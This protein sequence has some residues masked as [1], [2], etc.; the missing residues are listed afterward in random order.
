MNGLAP[1]ASADRTHNALRPTRFDEIVGQEK[2]KKLM[3]RAIRSCYDRAHPLPHTLLVGASGTGKS[4]FSHVIANELGGIDIYSCEAPVSTDL[5]AELRTTMHGGDILMIEEIHQQA[6]MERRG[7]SGAT[8]PE[9]LYS[10]MEDRVLQSPTGPLPFPDITIVGTTTDEGML[11][12]AFIN[13][14]PLRPRLVP[15]THEQLRT[16]VRSNARTL[17]VTLSD[18]AVRLFADASRGVPREI[19][20]LVKNAALLFAPGRRVTFADAEEVLDINGIAH[21]GLT[22]DMQATLRYMLSQPRVSNGELRYTAS[23]NSIAT[24]IGKSR[25]SKAIVLRVEPYLIQRGFLQVAPGL[26]RI[27]TDAGIVRA[28]ELVA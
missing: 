11:P 22:A 9:I 27:L 13:R 15:Y 20:N 3:R 17:R 5:L 28:K 6:I 2:A 21:D 23:V 19:N 26:G 18:E 10:V 4:T 25:D 7:R 8:Q 16:I 14:F 1:T 12:D 24:A